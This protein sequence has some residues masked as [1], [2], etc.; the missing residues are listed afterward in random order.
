MTKSQ[1]WTFAGTLASIA[2]ATLAGLTAYVPL[3]PPK[4]QIGIGIAG[5]VAGAVVS[6]YNQS[7]SSQHV[8]VPVERVADLPKEEIRKLGTEVVGQIKRAAGK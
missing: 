6:A 1:L 3:M 2:S 8:S 4:V 7:L 5:A